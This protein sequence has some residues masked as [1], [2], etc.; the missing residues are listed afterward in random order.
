M[1]CLIVV[2]FLYARHEWLRRK[3][4]LPAAGVHSQLYFD[5]T[6]IARHVLYNSFHEPMVVVVLHQ[7]T[8]PENPI[9]SWSSTN[10]VITFSSYQI[11]SKYPEDIEASGLWIDG[12]KRDHTKGFVAV[13]LSDRSPAM[14]LPVSKDERASFVED[15]EQMA[16]D[17][18]IEKWI[19][20]LIDAT[21]SARDTGESQAPTNTVP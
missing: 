19:Q 8:P 3:Y 9:S 4:G 15:A 14:D 21:E 20:P 7:A 17:A 10:P 16:G 6:R 12:V 1:A 13:Y 5:G 11:T 18:F 2:A